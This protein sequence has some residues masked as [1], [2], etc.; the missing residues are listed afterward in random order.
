MTFPS[1]PRCPSLHGGFSL[2]VLSSRGRRWSGLGQTRASG[3]SCFGVLSVPCPDSW[4]PAR[5]GTGMCNFPTWRCVRGLGLFCLWA[6]DL[7]EFPVFGVPAALDGEGLLI[8]TGPYSRGSPPYFFQLGA[9]RRESSV[10]D[11]L[12]RRLWC[13]VL[14]AT[15]RASVVSSCS[16]SELRAVFC[17]SS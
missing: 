13:R 10:S 14:S 5:D 9:R 1:V 6:L 8:P 17:K 3:G 2:A 4:V 16:L 15:M 12:Q 11:G 7:V